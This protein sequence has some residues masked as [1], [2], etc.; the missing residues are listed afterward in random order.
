MRLNHRQIEAFRAVFQTGGMTSAAELLG[1]SQPAVSRLIRDLE[2]YTRLPL[3][4]RKAG[5]VIPTTDAVA[6]Y[7][8]VQRSFLG[9]EQIGRVAADLSRRRSDTLRIAAS[10]APSFFCL[11]TV[12]AAYRSEFPGVSVSLTSCSSPEVINLIATH[13]CDIGV[14][15][16]PAQGPGVII[17]PL[18]EQRVVCVL[19][20][21]HAL[22]A[23]QV[24]RPA[25]LKE[26]P[27]LMIADYSLMQQRILQ[28]FEKAGVS[29]KAE[30]S[31]SYSGTICS[32]VAQGAGVSVLDAVTARAYR[33]SGVVVR[34][35]EPPVPYELRLVRSA[36]K[37]PTARALSF[38]RLLEEDLK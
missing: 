36:N 35:F 19:P 23:K 32:L 18:P 2:E 22:A 24:I 20:S 8:E 21:G 1:I 11:P 33:E 26:V 16:V 37:E 14:A 25:D 28:A 30:F 3:F 9:L 6:L 34:P 12:I 17:E 4:D 29:P 5:T 13:Q 27:L 31:C 7:Q 15:V 38:V 10:M